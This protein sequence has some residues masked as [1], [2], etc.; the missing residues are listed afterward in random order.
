MFNFDFGK[1]IFFGLDIG[2]S[3]IK[4][5]ELELIDGKPFLSNYAWMPLDSLRKKNGDELSDLDLVLPKYLKKIIKEA[6][7]RGKNA[8]VSVPASAGLI[9]PIDFPAMADEDIE[10]AIRFEAHKYVPIP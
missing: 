7:F 3:S 5:V 8:Y 6:K 2:T 4:A 1:N 10:Q 9:T